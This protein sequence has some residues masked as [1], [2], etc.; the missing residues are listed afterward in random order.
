MTASDA[1]C[2]LLSSQMASLSATRERM[3]QLDIEI[4]KLQRLLDPLLAEREKCSQTVADFQY[5]VLT[6]PAEITSEIFM[7]F[8]PSYPER[9][10]LIGP[11]SPSLLLQICRKWRDVALTTPAL[12]STMKLT[13]DSIY[14]VRQRHL[15]HVWLKRSGNR[16][17]SMGLACSF[18]MADDDE[19]LIEF[20]DSLAC[21][22]T[23]WQEMEIVLPCE[24]FRRI[25]GSMPRLRSVNIGSFWWEHPPETP[26]LLFTEAPA[27]K[28]VVLSAT[29]NP[30]TITLPWLQITTLVAEALSLDEAVEIL[31]QTTTLE[32]CTLTVDD[33]HPSAAS[34]IPP[35]PLRSLTLRYRGHGV[36]TGMV[37]RM[38]QLFAALNLPL[39]ETL[40]VHESFLGPDPVGALSRVCPNGYPRQIEIFSART[41]REIYAGAFPLASLS[42][43]E[44]SSV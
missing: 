37:A 34:L 29:F 6:L 38:F 2:L 16:S 19:I 33:G 27:L 40:V 9:P 18:G 31:R 42:V 4:E 8:L 35:L 44:E 26:I 32:H 41:P 36:S 22:A 13:L 25:T 23:R 10:S 17:L 39:L 21:Y 14:H 20:V 7:Q 30:L 11:Q 12:W 5:P 24:S 28:N 1:S 3:A 43:H 15:L